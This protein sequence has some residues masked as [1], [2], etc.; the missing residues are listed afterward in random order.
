MR[1]LIA[2]LMVFL[3]AGCGSSA[4][5]AAATISTV[6]IAEWTVPASAEFLP[7]PDPASKVD[8]TF[9]VEERYNYSQRNSAQR[10]T[11]AILRKAKSDFPGRPVLVNGVAPVTDSYG[12]TAPRTILLAFYEPATINRINF[13]EINPAGIWDIKD[14][15]AG[16]TSD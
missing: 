10:D 12:N 1:G 5:T 6:P 8:V 14:G 13:A 2:V 3:I 7:L 11:V 16:Y 15:G 4:R 9:N